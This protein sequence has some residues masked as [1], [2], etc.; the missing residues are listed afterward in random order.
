MKRYEMLKYG[1]EGSGNYL[2]INVFE[3]FVPRL[4]RV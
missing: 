4:F 1:A 2:Y 3:G